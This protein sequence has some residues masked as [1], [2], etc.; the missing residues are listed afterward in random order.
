MTNEE[1]IKILKKSLDEVETATNNFHNTKCEKDDF[2][3]LLLV[4]FFLRLKEHL[5]SIRL[6]EQTRD[7]L[8]VARSVVEAGLLMHWIGQPETKVEQ[9]KRAK[10][11]IHHQFVTYLE[12]LQAM[13]DKANPE[14]IKA[15]Q[16]LLHKTED[17]LKPYE[18][19]G[20]IFN[21]AIEI[22][23][24]LERLTLEEDIKIKTLRQLIDSLPHL[25]KGIY[26]R[27]YN[28]MSGYHHWNMFHQHATINE[29]GVLFFCA[30]QEI[31]DLD[32]SLSLKAI[33]T[34]LA[35]CAFRLSEYFSLGKE[36]EIRDAV[37][38]LP[39][40]D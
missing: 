34:V 9:S 10:K 31:R 39:T 15:I 37:R 7:H 17:I 14:H 4:I 35:E 23:P 36:S 30:S 33:T 26:E 21:E 12:R 13:G 5:V 11:Y 19:N 22:L 20:L 38:Q 16:N 18:Y 29:E 2:Y 25:D 24:L 27:N 1:K 8:L 3:G 6:L 32:Y 40:A 28:A